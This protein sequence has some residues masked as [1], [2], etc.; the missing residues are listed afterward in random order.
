[1]QGEGSADNGHRVGTVASVANIPDPGSRGPRRGLTVSEDT[2]AKMLKDARKARARARQAEA[3][4]KTA[5]RDLAR[6][7]LELYNTGLSYAQ[8]GTGLDMTRREVQRRVANARNAD[9][10]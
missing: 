3:A 9:D 7:C 8:I 4:A 1:M 5:H 10:T 6:R 2:V